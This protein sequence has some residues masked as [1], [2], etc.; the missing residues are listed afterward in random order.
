MKRII[1][2]EKRIVPALT[3]PR[4]NFTSLVKHGANQRPFHKIKR[5]GEAATEET[6]M[7]QKANKSDAALKIHRIVFDAAAFPTEDAVKAFLTEK[8]YADFTITTKDG[9]GFEVEDTPA[10][11]F[12][13]ALRTVEHSSVKGVS[14]I[15][16]DTS[17]SAAK[18]D[19]GA[20]TEEATEKGTEGASG[21]E[22]S[23]D[24]AD[25]AKG[26]DGA[27]PAQE[28]AKGA[29]TPA[30]ET[31]AA[32]RERVRFGLVVA[33][34]SM[35][36]IVADYEALADHAD[37]PAAKAEKSFADMLTNFTG[38]MPPGMY[39][40]A[41]AMMGELRRM[42]KAGEVDEKKVATL[43]T[44]F[45]RGVL[46][47]HSA[48]QSIVS[49]KAAPGAEQDMAA[50]EALLDV[51][52]AAPK[53]KGADAPQ[54]GALDGV[55]ALIAAL[56]EKTDAVQKAVDGVAVL[57]IEQA[58]QA[59]KGLPEITEATRVLPERKSAEGTDPD[60]EA[61]KKA[62]EARKANDADEERRRQKRLGFDYRG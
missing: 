51:L 52:F 47:M 61:T 29:D 30:P 26:A 41:D 60:P 53:A 39:D 3:N 48:F 4:P 57:V 62:E 21:A 44:D 9:G 58:Q 11:A 15:V 37:T 16:G 38:G 40:M 46:A 32:P 2:Q 54:A 14:F 24:T 43:A 36:R 45:T 20:G 42:I 5:A 31:K 8:G 25:T 19:A 23:G 50:L 28:E 56:S 1:P 12:K 17:E 27:A 49:T 59:A 18:A 10:D 22:G 6:A 55:A 35:N 13:G 34:K 33:N 7:G